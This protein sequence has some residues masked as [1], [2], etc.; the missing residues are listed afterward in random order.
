M[1]D[2]GLDDWLEERRRLGQDGRDEV[3]DGVHHAVPHARSDHGEFAHR[4]SAELYVSS[5]EVVV[6]LES[7][8]D[9]TWQ[10]VPFSFA[11]G[12]RDAWVISPLERGV[13]LFVDPDRGSPGRTRPPEA[14]RPRSSLKSTRSVSA[15]SALAPR[16]RRARARSSAA[17]SRRRSSQ[18]SPPG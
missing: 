14:R 12:V 5:G 11:R 6:E 17:V 3:W 16:A 7:P 13:R 4:L 15:A 8:G 9:E 10:E 18:A 2:G 1:N